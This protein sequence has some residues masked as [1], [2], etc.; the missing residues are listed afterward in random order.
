VGPTIL[1]QF[2]VPVPGYMD[3]KPIKMNPESE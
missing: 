3:G 2:G 1:A